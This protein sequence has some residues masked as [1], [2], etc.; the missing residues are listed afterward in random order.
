MA[1]NMPRKKKF[2]GV[3]STGK[4]MVAF[5][6]DEKGFVLVNFLL[7]GRRVNS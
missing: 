1:L 4:I 5:F 6:W 7:R 2:K 3:P